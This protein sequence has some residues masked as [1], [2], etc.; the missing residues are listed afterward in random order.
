VG[1]S[2]SG[3]GQDRG[4]N[5]S[6]WLQKHGRVGW[7]VTLH[8]RYIRTCLSSFTHLPPNLSRSGSSPRTGT[9]CHAVPSSTLSY[10]GSRDSLEASV[11]DLPSGSRPRRWQGAIVPLCAVSGSQ[12]R[13]SGRNS[14]S[15]GIRRQSV[16]RIVAMGSQVHVHMC[17]PPLHTVRPALV[18]R[19]S[20][21][22]LYHITL[23]ISLTGASCMFFQTARQSACGHFHVDPRAIV[24]SEGLL[25]CQWKI[26]M[27]PSGIEPAT[28]RF[29]AQYLS[30]CATISGPP[31]NRYITIFIDIDRV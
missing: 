10:V 21:T 26:P 23:V 30:H 4:I 20:W 9:A 27:T 16:Q 2:T 28:F 3:T 29:V 31:Q 17:G 19:M 24:Q 7:A 12:R 1:G 14:Q 11:N 15:A 13:K 25:V 18:G 6:S 8:V 5:R 22:A